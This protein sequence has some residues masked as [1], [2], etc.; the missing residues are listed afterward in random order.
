MQLL[1]YWT[2]SLTELHPFSRIPMTP[3]A[4]VSGQLRR[5]HDSSFH[6]LSARTTFLVIAG[7]FVCQ[8]SEMLVPHMQMSHWFVFQ[9]I[10]VPTGH[11][12]A[13]SYFC[14]NAVTEEHLHPCIW[15]IGSR[16]LPGGPFCRK[17]E[18]NAVVAL[19]S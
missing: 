12:F 19:C 4:T 16:C 3:L 18:W 10:G 15:L 5:F 13:V 11:L 7:A 1:I 17:A 9:P 2:A 8:L 14:S 6:A